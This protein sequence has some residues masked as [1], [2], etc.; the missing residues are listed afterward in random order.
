MIIQIHTPEGIINLDTKKN[1]EEDFVRYGLDKSEYTNPTIEE[2]LSKLEL[3]IAK[4]K[5]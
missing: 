1:S 3:D 5:T 2:R 4:L